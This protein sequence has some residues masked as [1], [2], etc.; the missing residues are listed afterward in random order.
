MDEKEF[1]DALDEKLKYYLEP[2][3]DFIEVQKTI[4]DKQLSDQSEKPKET[5]IYTKNVITW[6][7]DDYAY[8][9]TKLCKYCD[10][11]YVGWK[12]PYT[13]G[14]KP[15]AISM[16]NGEVIGEGCPKYN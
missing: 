8:S 13:S 3:M 1:F 15:I 9:K 16:V 4:R 12:Q 5:N 6:N 2:I 11:H 10:E 14:D 7:G